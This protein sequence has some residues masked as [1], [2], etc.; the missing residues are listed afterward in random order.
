MSEGSLVVDEF[1]GLDVGHEVVALVSGDHQLL[2]LAHPLQRL[3]PL[4]ILQVLPLLLHGL[5][6]PRLGVT[7]HVD[8]FGYHLRVLLLHL[9]QPLL[10]VRIC[11]SFDPCSFCLR[12]CDNVRFNEFSLSHNFI[13]LHCRIRSNFI[14]HDFS[15]LIDLC[16]QLPLLRLNGSNF[17]F[18]F[19]ELYFSPG[20]L[21]Q[22]LLL[23]HALQ[24]LQLLLVVLD[25]EV[26]GDGLAF[27]GV[28]VL[29]DGLLL[30]AASHI[31]R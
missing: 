31:F 1:E 5:Q 2:V 13:V 21:I 11:F 26:E 14:H 30:H 3:D 23:P 9:R 29:E 28:L 17:L 27:E 4:H 18:Y 12:I 20:L 24:K 10:V 25:S 22:P 8:G 19:L 15:I 7:L 16:L 6:L